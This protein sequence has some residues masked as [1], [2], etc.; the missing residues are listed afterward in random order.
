MSKRRHMV[1][2]FLAERGYRNLALR[3]SVAG[4]SV[5][6]FTHLQQLEQ[7]GHLLRD[8]ERDAVPLQIQFL[9]LLQVLCNQ[10]D[11]S[12]ARKKNQQVR[13]ELL[14][15]GVSDGVCAVTWEA[16]VDA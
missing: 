9:L 13:K 12:G 15:Q 8:N 14:H 6:Q 3:L 7:P 16:I 10:E 1:L 2:L 11:P 5:G 4:I